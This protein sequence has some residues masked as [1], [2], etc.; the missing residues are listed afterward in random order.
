MRTPVMNL[1]FAGHETTSGTL[2][3]AIWLLGRHPESR[4]LLEAEVAE[5][6][7]QRSPSYDDLA[8]LPYTLAVL[9]E[10]MRLYPAV[11]GTYDRPTCYARRRH[12]SR[13]PAPGHYALPA[14][15]L[16]RPPRQRRRWTPA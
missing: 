9:K 15:G 11:T 2:A 8:R 3:F 13:T 6:I 16:R 5:V 12:W 4:A 1:F 14:A 10:A 7:G